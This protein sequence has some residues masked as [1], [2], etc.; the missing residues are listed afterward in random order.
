MSATKTTHLSLAEIVLTHPEA[1]PIFRR[2]GLDFCCH[3]TESLESACAQ[4]H[5]AAEAVFAEV[6]A[7]Q[8]RAQVPPPSWKSLDLPA[9][10]V[11][12]VDRF[13]VPLRRRLDDLR[14]AARRVE[15]VHREKSDCPVGLSAHLE[16]FT[17]S[18]LTHMDKEEQTLF[19]ALLHGR[20][21]TAPLAIRVLM[22]EHEDHAE[23]LLR[24][25]ALTRDF[26]IPP[27]ACGTWRSLYL[28]LDT[29]ERELME[30][31]HVENHVLFP[32]ALQSN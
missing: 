2:L 15:T 11:A 5:L 32:K 29:L 28:G 24:T 8:A 21:G 4:R 10:V 14:A 26:E 27:A 16:S 6:V 30:H 23:A 20:A 25:R 31:V 17:Q 18:L 13:H 7:A 3:G 22:E 1:A 19:P 9:L 12:I